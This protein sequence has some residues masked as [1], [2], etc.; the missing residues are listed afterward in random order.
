[1]TDGGLDD[2]VLIFASPCAK[3]IVLK[4]GEA[5]SYPLSGNE[6]DNRRK[7]SIAVDKEC[8]FYVN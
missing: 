4:R 2:S 6:T 5:A 7:L 3:Q 1:M 8:K